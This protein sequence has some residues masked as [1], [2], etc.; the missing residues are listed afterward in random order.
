MIHRFA[1]MLTVVLLVV[2]ISVAQN[3]AAAGILPFSTQA[4]GT[5][6]SIDLAS[7]NILVAVPI[8]S[9]AGKEPFSFKLVSNSHAYLFPAKNPTGVWVL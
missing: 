7:S 8:R 4:G 6:D 1:G 9:K 3:D 5:Y 2:P